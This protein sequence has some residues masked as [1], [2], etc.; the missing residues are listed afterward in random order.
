MPKVEMGE[1]QIFLTH[2]E[3]V[4]SELLERFCSDI[5][6]ESLDCQ[7]VQQPLPGPQAGME[8]YVP[9]ALVIFVLKP[10]FTS[11]LEE[12]GKDHYVLLKK[13]LRGL[14]KHFFG[15]DRSLHVNVAEAGEKVVQPKYSLSLSI[16]TVIENERV[17]KFLIPDDCSEEEYEEGVNAFLDF[18]RSYHCSPE[19]HAI[20]RAEEQGWGLILIE[21]NK[22]TKSLCVFDPTQRD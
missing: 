20:N 19:R 17:I 6:A 13:S 7:R 8:W 11:F 1:A 9:T 18:V 21:Y 14:W 4:P 5:D 12:A 3:Q 15:R 10:Y 16:S 2:V 22:E